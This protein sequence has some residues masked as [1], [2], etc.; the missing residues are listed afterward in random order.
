MYKVLE[1]LHNIKKN[2]ITQEELD[3]AKKIRITSFTLGLQTPQELLTYNGMTELIYGIDNE[4]TYGN[5]KNNIKK[6]EKISLT[7]INEVA[8]ELFKKQHINIF[9]NGKSPKIKL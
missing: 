4:N 9:V 7:E 5:I 6:Y 8:D 1:E 2:G 3:K